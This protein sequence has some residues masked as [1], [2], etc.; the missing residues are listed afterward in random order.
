MIACRCR[1]GYCIKIGD[2]ALSLEGVRRVGKIACS[3]L[4]V[5]HGARDFAHAHRPSD[6]PLPTLSRFSTVKLG[7]KTKCISPVDI[8]KLFCVKAALCKA[9]DMVGR[10]SEREV[11]AKQHL[12]C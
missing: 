10:G 12:L 1:P 4:Q 8:R 3:A 11:R 2:C 5:G 6:P 7:H 9:F